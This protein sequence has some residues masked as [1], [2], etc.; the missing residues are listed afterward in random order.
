MDVR[1]VVGENVRRYRVAAGLS[2]EELAAR[3]GVAQSY[4]SALEAGK[5]NPTILTVWHAATAL[6]VG[7]AALFEVSRGDAPVVGRRR[8]A[9]SKK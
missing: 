1:R 5:R 6:K 3:V 2:Q 8:A 9:A 4:I 7:P